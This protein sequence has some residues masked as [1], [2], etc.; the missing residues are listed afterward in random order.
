[1]LDVRLDERVIGLQPREQGCLRA[2]HAI[3]DVGD[4]QFVV[5]GRGVRLRKRG[6]AT[7]GQRDEQNGRRYTLA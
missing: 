1:M 6:V 5:S 2:V 7:V 4:V 3:D